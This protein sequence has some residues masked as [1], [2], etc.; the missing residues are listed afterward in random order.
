MAD[1]K[2]GRGFMTNF[3][4][5][6]LI[7]L[8][9]FLSAQS[10]S[11]AVQEK[12]TNPLTNKAHVFILQKLQEETVLLD[13]AIHQPNDPRFTN[14]IFKF[15]HRWTERFTPGPLF[16]VNTTLELSIKTLWSILRLYRLIE[17]E[18]EE[19][20][21]LFKVISD[22]ISVEKVKEEI[23]RM[24]TL[25]KGE[26][27]QSVTA[28]LLLTLEFYDLAIEKEM[29]YPERLFPL[30]DNLAKRIFKSSDLL[31]T[32]ASPRLLL[33]LHRYF[34]RRGFEDKRIQTENY[35]EKGYLHRNDGSEMD[36]Q[37]KTL[38]CN[39]L[40]WAGIHKEFLEENELL[41]PDYED[42]EKR[43]ALEDTKRFKDCGNIYQ[44]LTKL[45]LID[46]EKLKYETVLAHYGDILIV[47]Y[48]VFGKEAVRY[49]LRHNPLLDRIKA[50]PFFHS[51]LV[52]CA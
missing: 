12:E 27:V 50:L 39:T 4:F 3:Y 47:L 7:L 26:K 13:E 15:E 23:R 22:H 31:D 51:G 37:G 10:P 11:G 30:T 41:F 20:Q 5:L 40:N 19:I 36:L 33:A 18:S 35:I 17:E 52:N 2:P 44:D 45:H 24:L 42:F 49:F 16:S 25:P 46:S 43:T 48:E 1:N 8:P 9:P 28:L 38:S 6:F 29:P 34:L 32:T 21:N 14:A